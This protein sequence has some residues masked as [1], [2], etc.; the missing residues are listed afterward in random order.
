[1]ADNQ[2]HAISK[3]HMRVVPC[4]H[5]NFFE[6]SEWCSTCTVN[7]GTTHCVKWLEVKG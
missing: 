2:L 5:W 1:L 3:L 7:K 6:Y 4:C